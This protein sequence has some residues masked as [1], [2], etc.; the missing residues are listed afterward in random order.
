MEFPL[1]KKKHKVVMSPG[2]P[3]YFDHYQSRDKTKEPLAIGGFNP[4][5]SVYAYDPT[6]NNLSEEERKYIL[7]AQANIWTEYILTSKQVEYMAVPRMCA[8][9]EV[10]WTN[11]NK[12]NYSDFIER[13]KEN[14]KLLDRMQVNYAKH[15]FTKK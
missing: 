1:Q 15:F 13:L 4:L 7:G 5:D 2:R 3:C 12:K 14:S 8:L 11:K 6:P 9:S 10:L